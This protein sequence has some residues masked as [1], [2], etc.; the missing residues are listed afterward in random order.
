VVLEDPGQGGKGKKEIGAG[1]LI[2]EFKTS[3]F[4]TSMTNRRGE[5]RKK[6]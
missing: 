5:L 2:M 1:R 3:F 4:K 6:K